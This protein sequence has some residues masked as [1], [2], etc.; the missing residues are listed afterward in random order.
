[1]ADFVYET[2]DGSIVVEDTKSEAT[3]QDRSYAIRK[4]LMA[5]LYGIQIRE[6]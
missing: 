1:M 3:V 6:V 5:A 2:L 4:R